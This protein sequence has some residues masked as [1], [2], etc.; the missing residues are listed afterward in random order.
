MVK[1]QKGYSFNL[2]HCL[3][4]SMV[5]LQ[6]MNLAYYYPIIFWNTA[7]LIVD[8]GAEYNAYYD[9]FSNIIRVKTTIEDKGFHIAQKPLKLMELLISLVT[10]EGQLI[11]DP[12]MGSG[13]T[14]LA[15]KNLHRHFTGID[16]YPENIKIAQERLNAPAQ[17]E[18]AL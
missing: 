1:P 8:S 14:C 5:A 15:A 16:I 12:F 9:T 13:T 10:T 2:A 17:C 3:S 18:M 4:Y 6:E 7:N 11:L